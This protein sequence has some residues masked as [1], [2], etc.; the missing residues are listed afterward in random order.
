M[1]LKF[2]KYTVLILLAVLVAFFGITSPGF[3]SWTNLFNLLRQISILGIVS[4]G[5]AI[6]IIT[7]EID[8]S[9]GSIVSFVSCVIAILISKTGCPAVIACFIG[10]AIAVLATVI[11]QAIVL[12][13]G[14]PAMLCTLATMQLYQGLTY[15]ITNSVPVY[16]LPDSMRMLGQGY[17]WVVP[18]PVVIMAIV[19]L[20][21]ELLLSCTYM[22]R[23]F[24]AVG[25]SYETARLSG[26]PVIK[27]KL[28]AYGICGLLVGIAA[29]IQ[30]S[31][32]FGGFPTA[33]SGLEMDAI[34]AVVV[35]GVSFAGGK[36]K[37][38]GVVQGVI[39]MGVLSN[40]LG[41]LGANTYTQLV[42]KGVV[43]LFV[44]GL[45]CYQRTKT[46]NGKIAIEG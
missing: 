24:Y 7:G 30:M 37:I 16:G 27:M 41:I 1:L 2:K 33:G 42:F 18:V 8:L 6:I 15:M 17:L 43:L 35:G 23:Y 5:M 21:V 19:F 45:D 12:F 44:V 26:I 9:V 39:L 29:C 34:T 36:G 28:L 4:T 38:R 14:M 40:G 20:A 46:K 10:I 22:G 25:S 11:N 32:L 13:T 3:A 31:R